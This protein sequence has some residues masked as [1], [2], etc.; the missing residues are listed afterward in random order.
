MKIHRREL[1]LI[2]LLLGATFAY[3]AAFLLRFD[4]SLPTGERVMFRLGL[5]TYL[6][7]QSMAFVAFRLHAARWRW[8]GVQDLFRVLFANLGGGGVA[9]VA[10][11]VLAGREF[12]RSVYILDATLSF[13][14]TAGIL[15]MGRVYCEVFLPVASMNKRSKGVLIYGAG[16]A[17]SM[18]GKEIQS[19]PG[20]RTRILGFL[21]DDPDKLANSLVGVPILGPGRDAGR[22]VAH[23]SRF[24]K[25][26]REIIIAMPSASASQMRAAID[27][28]RAA[29]VPFRTLPGISE[30]LHGRISG[31]VR[32]VSPADLLGREQV[33]ID[34]TRIAESVRG[35]SVMVTGGCG[36]IGSELCRQ[37]A[38]FSPRKLVIFDQAESE[39][40]M[41]AM[42]LRRRHPDLE[43]TTEIGDIVHSSRVKQ[44]LARHEVTMVFHA[45]A[46]KHVPLMEE[47]IPEAVENNVIGSY[48]VARW[49]NWANV[50][51]FILIST[52]KAVNPTSIMGVTKRISELLVSATPLDGGPPS[53]AF[54]SVRFGNVLGSAGSVIP[55]FQ[56]QI[57]AGGPVTITHRDMRRFFMSISEAVQ[58]VLQA[59]TFGQAG[60]VFVLD[61]G[62]AVRIIDLAENMIRLA[63][64]VPGRDI[65]IRSTGL[66]PGE[67]LYEEIQLDYE[68]IMPTEHEKIMR[69]RSAAPD[70]CYLAGWLEQLR[71]LLPEADPATLKKHLLLLVPEYQGTVPVVTAAERPVTLSPQVLV[72]PASST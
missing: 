70:R 37:L 51:K 42:E 18:L 12:P 14:I 4:F 27:C 3:I 64:L 29:G 5:C 60:E 16:A 44:A 40:Y 11:L 45:A 2:P 21:D 25:S 48:E 59:S 72:A 43:L 30:L 57:A 66:R 36:S 1:L 34:E 33:R 71:N 41:L 19:D 52:D 7:L 47:N 17:G 22:I 20:L 24:G 68:D 61:M 63:G 38:G 13:L 39:M 9:A 65:E 53:G 49:A 15:L 6:P 54:V 23:L 58:L 26:P 62:E 56:R 31:Q 35:E 28:C 46:Y 50:R 69:F 10:T 55:I 67:K 8:A 32:A